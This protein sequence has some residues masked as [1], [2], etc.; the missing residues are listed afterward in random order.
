MI[1]GHLKNGIICFANKL[2][3]FRNIKTIL[4]FW[5]LANM[6]MNSKLLMPVA[7]IRVCMPFR[8]ELRMPFTITLI[9]WILTGVANSVAVEAKSYITVV[10]IV[11]NNPFPLFV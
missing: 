9:L 8:S 10:S 6:W 7:F 4:L 2:F 3:I 1:F 5:L 11:F